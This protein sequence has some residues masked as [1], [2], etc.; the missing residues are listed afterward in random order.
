MATVFVRTIIIYLV[1]IVAIRL[2]GKRQV[3]EMELSEL[4]ITFLL[5][6]LATTPIQNASIPLSYAIIPLVILLGSEVILSFLMTKSP[7]VKKVVFGNP[8][9]IIKGGVLDQGELGRLR[10]GISE[11]LAQLRLL[12]IGDINDVEYAILEQNGKL[13]VFKKENSNTDAVAHALVID[14]KINRNL[15]KTLNKNEE[16]ILSEIKAR[17]LELNDI[18]LLTETDAGAINIIMKEI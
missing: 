18:F 9:Y 11:L 7:F 15:I 12:E 4:V 16:D 17:Q 1:F 10:I 3:G 5:S 14:G 8:S 13:S 6:E 2:M